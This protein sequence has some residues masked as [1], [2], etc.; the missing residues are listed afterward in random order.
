MLLSK[1]EREKLV[2]EALDQ[3]KSTRWIA[4]TYHL[5]FSDIGKIK[6]KYE[7]KGQNDTNDDERKQEKQQQQE[8]KTLFTSTKAFQL[9]SRDKNPVEVAIELNISASEVEQLYMKPVIYHRKTYL[10]NDNRH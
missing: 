1:E 7:P 2:I 3:G 8:V 6:A 9:F 4:E 5:S 10:T